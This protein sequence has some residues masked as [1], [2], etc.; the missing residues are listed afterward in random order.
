M[1]T[2]ASILTELCVILSDERIAISEPLSSFKPGASD[3]AVV[4]S[5]S[6]FHVK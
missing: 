2:S 4:E 6:Q 1:P 5:V 3:T